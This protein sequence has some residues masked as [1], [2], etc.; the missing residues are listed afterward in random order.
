MYERNTLGNFTARGDRLNDMAAGM[1]AASGASVA[2]M[3]K[4]FK[5]EQLVEV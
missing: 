4:R 5:V 3:L 1:Y 2:E